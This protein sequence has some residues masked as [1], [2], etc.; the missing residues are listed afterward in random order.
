MNLI[1]LISPK[2]QRLQKTRATVLSIF[3]GTGAFKNL[4]FLLS[5]NFTR[6]KR[7]KIERPIKFDHTWVDWIFLD[8]WTQSNS[9]RADCDHFSSF[10]REGWMHSGNVRQELHLPYEV[11][12]ILDCGYECFNTLS[13]QDGTLISTCSKTIVG[14]LSQISKY[15]HWSSSISIKANITPDLL[16]FSQVYSLLPLLYLYVGAKVIISSSEIVKIFLRNQI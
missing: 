16:V 14:D 8:C 4:P 2:F 9:I 13:H 15:Y 5:S 6:I 7:L 3:W 11:Q 1:K 10:E 12:E